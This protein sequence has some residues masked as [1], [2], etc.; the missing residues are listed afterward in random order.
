MWCEKS[1]IDPFVST[2][3]LFIDERIFA[4][5]IGRMRSMSSPDVIFYI[6]KIA[7]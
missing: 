6:I 3:A 1:V 7:I 4:M 5:H 2:F